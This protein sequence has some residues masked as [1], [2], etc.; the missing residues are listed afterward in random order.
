MSDLTPQALNRP[1]SFNWIFLIELLVCSIV[2]IFFLFYFNRVFA[3]IVSVALRAYLRTWRGSPVYIDIQSLQISLLAGRIFFRRV[4]YH[5][6]NETIQIVSGHITWRYWL[7]KVRHC[8]NE[9]AGS[10]KTNE[11]PSRILVKLHGLEWFVYNR[12]PAYDAIWSQMDDK[13]EERGNVESSLESNTG[14]IDKDQGYGRVQ[15]SSQESSSSQQKPSTGMDPQFSRHDD[16]DGESG[17][18]DCGLLM[19]SL[20]LRLLP[21]RIE[22]HKGGIVMG[23]NNTPSIIVAKFREADGTIEATS[24]RGPDCYKQAFNLHFIDPVISIKENFDYRESQ[25]SR[26]ARIM[27]EQPVQP[28][29]WTTVRDLLPLFH[30]SQESLIPPIPPDTGPP[31][32]ERWV[33][34]AR[35]LDENDEEERPAFEPAEYAVVTT[36]LDSRDVQLNM[37][38]DVPGEVPANPVQS[39]SATEFAKDINGNIPPQW[40][41][42][43][44]ISGGTINYGP[45]ADRQRFE[46]QNMFFPRLYK[47]AVSSKPLEP[48]AAR[49]P[50]IFELFVELK[51]STILRIPIREESKDWKY[52]RKLNEGE[53]R[54]F[55]WIDLKVGAGSTISN[56]MAM[57]ASNTGWD[58]KLNLD[59]K[60]CE[61][62]SSVNNG[63]F[64]QTE[65]ISVLGD[66]SNP[67]RWNGSRHW[68]FDIAM[69]RLKLFLLREHVTLLTDLVGDWASGPPQDYFIFSPFKYD[70]NLLST[71][72]EIYLN[73]ND[74]NIINNPSDLDDNTFLV[75]KGDQLKS[76]I[77]IPM[78]R[79]RP[80]FNEIPFTVDVNTLKLNLHTPPW[81]TQAS[82]LEYP[83]VAMVHDFAL[84][85]KYKYHALTS[86]DLID[87][88]TLDI[89][90]SNLGFTFYG[91]LIRYFLIIREN[92]FGENVHF[93]TL[94]EYKRKDPESLHGVKKPNTPVNGLDVILS[95]EVKDS[96]VLLPAHIYSAKEAIRLDVALLNLD[97]RFT[98]PYMD[99][100][101]NGSPIS[102]SLCSVADQ[103]DATPKGIP[104]PAQLFLDSLV[105]YGHRLFGLPPTEPTYVCN[106]D[107]CFGDLRGECNV[108]FIR[109]LILGLKAFDFSLD[110]IENALPPTIIEVL[111]DATFLRVVVKSIQIWARVA[112][113]AFLI[114]TKEFNFN[115]NDWANEKFSDSI[116]L[117]LPGVV[118]ACVDEESAQRQRGKYGSQSLSD[119]PFTNTHA[120]LST[121]ISMSVFGRKAN[122]TEKL[123]LQQQHI[124]D[125][126]LSTGRAAFLLHNRPT[127]FHAAQSPSGAPL[128]PPPLYEAPASYSDPTEQVSILETSSR[129]SYG[130]GRKSSFLVSHSASSSSGTSNR[131]AS[132][133]S[134]SFH[135]AVQTVSDTLLMTPVTGHRRLESPFLSNS[136]S[137]SGRPP[138]SIGKRPLQKPGSHSHFSSA[139]T[140][141]YFPLQEVELDL[142][143]VPILDPRSPEL[144]GDENPS[145]NAP[146]PQRDDAVQNSI[147]FDFGPGI[148]A[149]CDFTAI[150]SAVRLAQ[151]LEP[152]S[153]EDV[154]DHIQIT[155]I[156]K[157]GKLAKKVTD[158]TKILELCIRLP[159]LKFR[160][161]NPIHNPR[162]SELHIDEDIF[163]INLTKAIFTAR[164]KDRG[165]IRAGT[166]ANS[167]TQS[168]LAFRCFVQ[169]LE[170]L[171]GLSP[172]DPAI[173]LSIDDFT[174]FGSTTELS[175]GTVKVKSISA[176]VESKHA[177]FICGLAERTGHIVSKLDHEFSRLSSQRK[178]RAQDLLYML[179]KGQEDHGISHEPSSI[180]RPSYVLRSSLNH[181]RGHD[182]WKI[183]SRLRHIYKSLPLVV[184]HEIDA[185][186]RDNTGNSPPDARR[187]VTQAFVKWRGWELGN[188]QES[189]IIQ[190][191]FGSKRRI[192]KPRSLS[193]T[194]KLVLRLDKISFCIDPGPTQQQALIDG[195]V[196]AISMAH[197]FGQKSIDKRATI[198]E[199]AQ[200][201]TIIQGHCRNAQVRLTWE[202]LEAV[203]KIIHY[204]NQ[205]SHRPVSGVHTTKKLLVSPAKRAK[206]KQQY[207]IVLTADSGSIG[208]ETVNLKLMCMGHSLRASMVASGK[209]TELQDGLLGSILVRSDLASAE[210]SYQNKVLSFASLCQPV[211][212]IFLDQHKV[213]E[214]TINYWK[215]TGSCQ[216]LSFELREEVLGVME[217]IEFVVNDEVSHLNRMIVDMQKAKAPIATRSSRALPQSRRMLNMVDLALKLDNFSIS[218]TLLPSL[219][220]V[221]RGG[222]IR[223]S[224]R[225][226]NTEL[227]L[228]FDLLQHEHEVRTGY[229]SNPITISL[230][231]I[232]AINGRIRKHETDQE[233]LLEIFFSSE[234]IEFDAS[235]IQSLLNAL[236]KP[237]VVSVIESARKEWMVTE[238]RLNQIFG[239]PKAPKHNEAQKSPLV[240]MAHVGIAGV[241]IETKAPSANLEINLGA[242]QVFASNKPSQEPQPLKIPEIFIEL[243]HITVGLTKH[244]PNG[245]PEPCGFIG[246][247]A[248]LLCSSQVGSRGKPIRAFYVKSQSFQVDLFAE[249][250]PTIVDVAGH[251][252]DKLKDLDLSPEVKY[253]KGLRK[254]NKP[255]LSNSANLPLPPDDEDNDIFNSIFSVELHNMQVSWIVG[256]SI[257]QPQNRPRQNLVLS[258]KRIAFESA[259]KKQNEARLIIEELLL[260]MI[261]ENSPIPSIRAENSALLPEIVFV[262]AHHNGKTER[263]F[264]S[265]AKGLP[266]DLRINPS[267]MLGVSDLE[268]SIANASSKFRKASASWKSTPTVSG[269]ERKN[270]FGKKRLSS[271]L[272]DADF[273][274]AVVYFQSNTTPD[275]QSSLPKNIQQGRFGQFSQGDA[276][277]ITT[278][279]TPG[280]AFKVQYLDPANEDPSISG[281][282]KVSGSS[283]TIYPSIVPLIMEM[284]H[285]L[286]DVVRESPQSP[287]LKPVK[288]RNEDKV[289]GDA[290]AILGRCRLSL[291]LRIMKQEFSL[292]CQPFARVAATA[293]YNDI[294]VTLNT[295]EDAES[296]RFY[297]VSAI[298]TGLRCSLQ[299]IYSRE[300]TGYLEVEAL[301]ISVMNNRHLSG[302]E[303]LSVIMKLS[304]LKAQ[305]NVKQIQD[306]LLFREIWVPEE[307]TSRPPSPTISPPEQPSQLMQKYHKVTATKA[308]PWNTTIS[309]QSIDLQLDLGPSLGKTALQMSNFWI[310]SRKSSD[311]EQTMCLG[312]GSISI[313][314]SGRL[315]GL[316]ELVN[317]RART[318]I[319]W[320]P[321]QEE[322]TP[323]V[324]ASLGFE[325]FRVKAA[326]DYHPF[327][328]A[329][330]AAFDFLMYNLRGATGFND[331]LV[332]ILEGDKVQIFC[333][334]Q[335]TAHGMALYQAFLRLWQEKTASYETS[336]KDIEKFIRRRTQSFGQSIP[337][338]PVQ[339]IPLG[340][341]SEPS[342]LTLHTDVV[343]NLREINLGAFPST[344]RDSQVFK[345]EALNVGARF[346][347]DMEGDKLHSQ[348]GMTLGQLRVALSGVRKSDD[349]G[350]AVDV[351]IEDVISNATG[352]RGGTIL[353]V[354]QVNAA[355]HTWSKANSNRIDYIFKSAFQG[356]VDVG[357]NYARVSFI[358]GMW[359][360][361]LQAIAQRKFKL[362][363]SSSSTTRD[364]QAHPA[365]ISISATN[366]SPP[367]PPT[368]GSAVDTHCQSTDRKVKDTKPQLEAK[369][370]D[371]EKKGKITA[372]VNVPQS[373]Y[374]YHPLEPPIIETPQL[375]DMGEATPPLEWIGLNRDRL[376]NLTHQIVIVSLLEVAR[377]VEDAY[378]KILG[379]G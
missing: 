175:T 186:C 76:L 222:G 338:S 52:R 359:A 165:A 72:F 273:A 130:T 47:D 138:S 1:L 235:A 344:F 258:L 261:N 219:I 140:Q 97:L 48:G 31:R 324:Q 58:N 365:T 225:P 180:S 244:T 81:S 74:G 252:Q 250:A 355:M 30:L 23:N 159:Q 171:I 351:K 218:A 295:C 182:S 269:G 278:L 151:E 230:L 209:S 122:A 73:V 373:R 368:G 306:F 311:W 265:Q 167:V 281:E 379:S 271:V 283:N 286:K 101:V 301:A 118:I 272:V 207:H 8:H 226:K 326:F 364:S 26:G 38:W 353:K 60:N 177:T 275:A 53:V 150:K 211:F 274:G 136:H 323:L 314:A 358:K 22:C 54:G 67:L 340:S 192:S 135:S 363:P 361:H 145:T 89:L 144:D 121:D 270:M 166:E 298:T 331:R 228:E 168:G 329:D 162:G 220:Y 104:A 378:H 147:I 12:S 348:L 172:T 241:K 239:P 214:S 61:I 339:T 14:E 9:K 45:W 158:V 56:S 317:L 313:N 376:P 50:T 18:Q 109:T 304:P 184:Q 303:G 240:Y 233:S 189:Y 185:R 64:L 297:S 242:V 91:V 193:S 191:V 333:T 343:V 210:L 92:Y 223:L 356:K 36:I 117:S 71:D 292:S 86:A 248:S 70:L 336:L 217:V 153:A 46:L 40:G 308:F 335:S 349:M 309:I 87:T 134:R 112:G 99:L 111:H 85:G 115:F 123:R 161:V 243:R 127:E 299:H 114:S 93:K 84:S 148:R 129:R 3:K 367:L 198:I 342:S 350:M 77:Q 106:W 332:A 282:I 310:A 5:G 41:I 29:L 236:N 254:S 341:K 59:L 196:A 259:I 108:N 307:I 212:Y 327:L 90:G 330:I 43:L 32:Q 369:D 245:Q 268:N 288:T 321:N 125:H 179:A 287:E 263:R 35:Y 126:D 201:S 246:L 69:P 21:I 224:T 347:V 176:N 334:S 116:S 249:T 206:F 345:L 237:E 113:S 51:E 174:S 362:H 360:N 183:N 107:L 155:V 57:V 169:K 371:K 132:S 157:L 44:A 315:S 318:S 300:S 33:G 234:A 195:F 221:V 260:Q 82:F 293:T 55:G 98:N 103:V 133:A 178:K 284:S 322:Q 238:A 227:I 139:Y 325:Q 154:L 11:L 289:S 131:T 291:G 296:G 280:L 96:F 255:A 267:C 20:Y 142:R 374:E 105:I 95:V 4:S 39:P 276:T 13:V 357:W 203:E 370:K 49:Q 229:R 94:E 80:P 346:A 15:K 204:L 19:D 88:L 202:I 377:E 194:A 290:A 6:S 266:L 215:A 352:A 83:E 253:L 181:V 294:Y 65:Q 231:Q 124:R 279:R 42:D 251:L 257:P 187:V 337:I 143:N 277:G 247:H 375:R 190:E 316:I 27:T 149:F 2:T 78:H 128:M 256:N 17:G 216:D 110:D 37:Y 205:A 146:L 366:I 137:P 10:L 305:I 66:I 312:L 63:L 264:A 28:K 188:I 354:P 213:A 170:V 164:S 68:T 232:P 199:S 100:L 200:A 328:I 163:Q 79:L 302:S 320:E 152:Q 16:S 372:V 156:S 160:F 120:Y 173:K 208:L 102:A 7:R 62:R 119:I 262:V 75:L 141:P 285:S 197:V 319:Q 34:L 25:L 24:S